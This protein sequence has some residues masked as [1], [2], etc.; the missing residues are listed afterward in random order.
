MLKRLERTTIYQSTWINLY[1]D[2]VLLP[3]GKIIEKYHQ[4]DYPKESVVVYSTN[5]KNEICFIKALRYTS[6]KENQ[7]EWEL[8]AGSIE[9][10]ESIIEAAI[11]E[12]REETGYKLTDVKYIY[13]F[14][15]SNGMSNQKVHVLSGVISEQQREDFDHD[16]ISNVCWLSKEETESLIQNNEINDGISLMALLLCKCTN[17]IL[18]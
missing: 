10:H 16:E 2:K 17:D 7:V 18:S 3:S 4:L 14:N 6:E 5:E 11:R 15:P 9:E 1:T 8:V 12:T 13:Q